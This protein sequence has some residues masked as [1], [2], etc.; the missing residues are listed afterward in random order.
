MKLEHIRHKHG[1]RIPEIYALGHVTRRGVA[2][3]FYLGTVEWD[4]GTKSTG[5]E[6]PP[7]ALCAGQAP[8]A[9]A[10]VNTLSEALSKYLVERGRWHDPIHK[11][12]GRMV[13]WTPK[14]SSWTQRLP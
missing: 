4:D 3:W 1:G 5:A 9:R 12:D 11:R 7:F 2:D 8:E 14:R 13:R 10:E 6:I